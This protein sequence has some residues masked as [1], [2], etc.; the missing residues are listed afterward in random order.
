MPP[1][2]LCL[3]L[4]HHTAP[5]ALRERF[6]CTL[7]RI[8][9]QAET[10][11]QELAL[12][13]TCNRIELYAALE[14]PPSRPKECM[15]ELLASAGGLQPDLFRNFSYLLT[16]G[17]AVEHLLRV[18]A[19]LDSLVLGEPQILG[20]VTE[21][22]RTAAGQGMAGLVLAALFQS[23]VRTGKR[24]RTETAIG[25]NPA[26]IS[27]VAV[28]LAQ[29]QLGDLS[30]RQILIVGAGEMARL[31]IKAM[32]SRRFTHIAVANRTLSTAEA[33]VAEWNGRS[34]TL[35]QLPEAIAEAD[36]VFT[37]AR[38][39]AP[40]IDERTILARERPFTRERPLIFI[41]IAVPRN[42]ACPVADLP[43]IQLF[44]QD[45]L[46]AVLDESLTARQAEIP[47]VEAIIAEEQERLAGE[48]R[49]LA[50]K[51]LIVDMRRKAEQIRQTE[52]E[53]TLRYLGDLD[54]QALAH[55][56]HF[57]RS[58]VNKL[59]HEPTTR[60]REAAGE[61]TAAEYE[62]AVRALFGLTE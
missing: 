42:V 25:N 52:L 26:S 18:A 15:V 28:N 36:V 16:D 23:A 47:A 51:P 21:A 8:P 27:S 55:I 61:E 35:E 53:R 48:L 24:A 19:G 30:Q 13:S 62:T 46:Q 33:M 58:L 22:Y 4:N 2:I 39:D 31:A 6:S 1:T 41:D 10:A 14:T 43:H 9:V 49:R 34:Y 56:Q 32:R 20:Q 57:S 44:D 3:G 59:L 29:Q 12:L 17:E 60:L 5:L 38:T 45:D 11:V 54:P 7:D 40:I 50:V 37:T